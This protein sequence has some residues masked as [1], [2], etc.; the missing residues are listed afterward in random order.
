MSMNQAVPTAISAA[1]LFGLGVDA[2]FS[3]DTLAFREAAAQGALRC[4]HGI[5]A[6]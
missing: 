6:P 3:I 5:R 2:L 1:V 4:K